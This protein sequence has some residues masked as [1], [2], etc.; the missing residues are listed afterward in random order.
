M[1]LANL[2]CA[3]ELGFA[4][5]T[6]GGGGGQLVLPEPVRQ[7]A[8]LG[9]RDGNGDVARATAAVELIDKLAVSCV[10]ELKVQDSP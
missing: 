8:G 7:C 3:P 2:P 9:C 5:L 10:A 4:E 1:T 6:A